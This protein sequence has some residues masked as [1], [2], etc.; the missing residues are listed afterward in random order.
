MKLTQKIGVC[1]LLI[2]LLSACKKDEKDDNTNLALLLALSGGTTCAVTT[3]GVTLP[4]ASVTPTR[5]T[6]GSPISFT[7]AAGTGIGAVQVVGAVAQDIGTF[8][9]PIGN[10][11][12]AV[13]KG[14]CPINVSSNLAVLNTDY[15]VQSGS[16]TSVSSS[17]SIKFLVSGNY[18]LILTTSNSAQGSFGFAQ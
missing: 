16:L 4:I 3:S 11:S 9:A 6:S 18:T 5:N 14:S 10:Y 12:V 17:A 13:Y 15:S 7:T 8:T 1:L 2:S